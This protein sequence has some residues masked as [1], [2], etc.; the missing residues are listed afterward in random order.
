MRSALYATLMLAIAT[1][2]LA[3]GKPSKATVEMQELADKMNNPLAQQAMTGALDAMLATILDVKV[4]GIAKALEPLNGGKKIKMKGS[5]LGEIAANDD[6]NFDKK[7]QQGTRAMV[8][9][10]GAL[11]GALAQAM[12]ELEKAM[13]E[14][15]E[16]M[17][18]VG[19]SLP[20]TR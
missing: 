12:P 11:T 13:D 8:G 15:E 7:L 3:S 10:L 18:K 6:K 17:D 2:A 9:G 19:K 16:A 1:P 4:D 5:T 14:M 20:E